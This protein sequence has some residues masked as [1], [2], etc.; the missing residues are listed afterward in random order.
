V[1]DDLP[2]ETIEAIRRRILIA[3]ALYAFGAALCL[4]STYWS[5]GFI[6]AVQLYY[7]VA[8]RVPGRT[9]R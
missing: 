9:K 1:K 5:I 2:V 6:V 8:P 3:Q 4:V 7:A